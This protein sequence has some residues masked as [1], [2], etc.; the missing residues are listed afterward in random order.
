MNSY[1][2]SAGLKEV[3]LIM[4][5]KKKCNCPYTASC[6]SSVDIHRNLQQL[7]CVSGRF[8]EAAVQ[9]ERPSAHISSLELISSHR[10]ETSCHSISNPQM[11][12]LSPLT[13]VPV[14]GQ[15]GENLNGV[16]TLGTRSSRGGRCRNQRDL[17]H[18]PLV[19][20][21]VWLIWDWWRR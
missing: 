2:I 12:P 11:V 3:L 8:K 5:K 20:P 17:D 18:S 15:T 10:S 19:A 6:T 7:K 1:C 14:S 4:I 16:F 13:A 9:T 21:I